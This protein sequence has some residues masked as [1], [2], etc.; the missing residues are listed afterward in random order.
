MRTW[1]YVTAAVLVDGLAGL[2]GAL[3]PERR[4][5]TARK[6]LLGFAAGVLL[7]VVFLD[8]LPEALAAAPVSVAMGAALAAFAVMT[9]VEWA[10]G[11][12]RARSAHGLRA[13]MFLGSDALHNI[14]DGAAIAAAFL[15]SP[16]VGLVTALAVI[17]HEVPEEIGAYALLR[18]TGM[19][20]RRALVRM[21]VVQLTAAIGA[22]ATLVGSSAWGALSGVVLAVASGTFLFIGAADLLPEV[23]RATE[24]PSRGQA[25]LGFLAGLLAVAAGTL[26]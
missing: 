8:L 22:A 2:A 21:A 24:G 19:P 18:S 11:A 13:P 9:C 6:L 25:L 3:I 20:R 15:S 14:G 17:V 4:I 23:L 7:A 26:L 16:R 1:I 10:L 12:R 5:Q